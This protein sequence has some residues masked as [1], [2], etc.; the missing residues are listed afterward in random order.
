MKEISELE[1]ADEILNLPNSWEERGIK[2]GIEK[3][4]KQIANRMLEEGSSID[5]ISK[6]TGLKKEEVEKLE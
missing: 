6:I 5:F 2:K 3:G 1:N 4:I